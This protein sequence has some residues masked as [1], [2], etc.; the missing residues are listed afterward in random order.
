M[1][2]NVLSFTEQ[3][4]SSVNVQGIQITRG[5]KASL[6]TD[7]GK[8]GEL[9][10]G[11]LT[12]DEQAKIEDVFGLICEKIVKQIDKTATVQSEDVKTAVKENID[13]RP[14]ESDE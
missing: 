7:R 12:K 14:K 10:F 13:L 5:L 6:T 4:E 1:S 2:E 3:I 9:F 11:D 8:R